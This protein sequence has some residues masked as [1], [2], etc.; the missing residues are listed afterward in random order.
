[1]SNLKIVVIG[2]GSSY[3]PE[4]IEGYINRQHELPISEIWLVDVE[5]GREKVE[6]VG[7]MAKRMV[8]AAGLNWKVKTTLNRR[9]AL[10]GAHFVSTQFRV[11]Q[12]DAR[13]LDERIPLSHGVLGQETTGAGGIFKALRTIPVILDIV[14]D[15]KELCPNAWLI[16]FTNPAGMITE[17][18]IYHGGWK[19]TIG[20]CN[21]P[22]GHIKSAEE[23][24]NAPKGGLRFK[25]AG[26][27]HFHWHRVWDTQGV[28]R[29][30]ELIDILYSP[31]NAAVDENTPK[32]IANAE[33]PYELIKTSGL[34]PSYYHRYYYASEDTLKDAIANFNKGTTRAEE[35]KK[36]EAALFELYKDPNLDHKPEELSKRGGAYYSDAACELV[37]SIYNNKG[38]EMVV[39]VQNNGAIPD[40]PYDCVVELSGVVTAHGVETYAH[41]HFAPAE[42]G[43]LQQ[44]KAMEQLTIQA[45]I[46][47]DYGKALYAFTLNPLI[48][49]GSLAKTI[50]DEMLTAHKKYLPQ[51]E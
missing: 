23:K 7:Q 20:L 15:M 38:T 47:C 27:N 10:K 4:L 49:S 42:R 36:T 28:E 34:L 35:V 22:I 18:A 2:G 17:A 43:M 6:I 12:L 48:P 51:F 11:G 5:A 21:V 30:S 44:L 46:T 50:L 40:L 45:A 24:L 26:L 29:T 8:A 41:G 39:S 9:E 25:F 1:M 14:K 13:I 31:E 33:Y 32:N 19:K 16:N 37:A 3:T